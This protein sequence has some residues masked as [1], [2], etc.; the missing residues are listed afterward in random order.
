MDFAK[1]ILNKY[2][3]KEGEGLGRNNNGIKA[4]IKANLKFNTAGFGANQ[5]ADVTNTWWK[6][7]Y[8]D[9][10]S[11][12]EVQGEKE[13]D[14]S[15]SPVKIR[16]VDT[17]AVE[18]TTNGYSL[19]KLKRKEQAGNA[20]QSS[21]YGNVFIKASTLLG[22]T[23]REI[24]VPNH[25]S[26]EDIEFKPVKTMTDE[27][28]FA[29]CGGR[30]AHK[31][32]RHGLNLTGKLARIEEQ[33]NKLLQELESKSFEAVIKSNDWQR[34][35]SGNSRKKSKKQK[36][37]EQRWLEHSS[38]TGVGDEEVK[39]MVHHADYVVAKNKKKNKVHQQTDADLATTMAAM[40]SDLPVDEGL[41][42][43]TTEEA[44]KTKKKSAKKKKSSLDEELDQLSEKIRKL[45]H[46]SVTIK[47]RDKKKKKIT[48][49][50]DNDGNSPVLDPAA[51]Y[52]K[53][54]RRDLKDNNRKIK[55]LVSH[56]VP[57]LETTIKP[58]SLLKSD[59]SD[60]EE[61][62]VVQRIN[63]EQNRY[64]K[65]MRATVPKINII[66]PTE[67]DCLSL[68]QSLKEQ[69]KNEVKR[70]GRRTASGNRKKNKKKHRVV[71]QL[72]DSLSKNL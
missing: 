60:A 37:N 24:D 62:D 22:G 31:G 18:I 52:R 48:G 58:V 21:R 11:N 34:Q 72:A 38:S 69:H 13:K 61:E 40:Y 7:V 20:V 43:E 71:A 67:D 53:D 19:N 47:K 12:I 32:A 44:P 15:T 9:A 30:T 54:Y 2:G 50:S 6:R 70:V 66:E 10:A 51:K 65:Q 16:Q 1:N 49:G 8:D 33:N 41:G 5:S 35:L 55:S 4:P 63:E 17:D 27:Q 46:S 3:W 26:T 68:G 59:S 45:D 28:L 39:D 57:Q 36:R 29:A 64:W 14:A 23:G 56:E 25:V 42:D